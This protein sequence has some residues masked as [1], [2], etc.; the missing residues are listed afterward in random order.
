[1]TPTLDTLRARHQELAA[2]LEAPA[3]DNYPKRAAWREELADLDA[4]IARG[5]AAHAAQ[6]EAAYPARVAA[7]EAQRAALR[8]DLE[9]VVS[10]LSAE[11][12]PALARLHERAAVEG[13]RLQA[14]ARAL[15]AGELRRDDL[16]E[17]GAE[18]NALVRLI[19]QIVPLALQSAHRLAATPAAPPSDAAPRVGA[20]DGSHLLLKSAA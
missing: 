12:A 15:I 6:A 3:R 16:H 18:L 10:T 19:G 9:G 11:L 4:Q 20:L 1:M 14:E 7:L 8:A 2:Q 5:A 13:A 17:H